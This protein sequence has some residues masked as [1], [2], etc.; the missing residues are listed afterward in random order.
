MIV[1]QKVERTITTQP[2]SGDN[3]GSS[4]F[5]RSMSGVS[6]F[7]RDKTWRRVEYGG[8]SLCP[9]API[10]LEAKAFLVIFLRKLKRGTRSYTF[11]IIPLSDLILKSIR[12]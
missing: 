11:P 1:V 10:S 7:F 9:N 8:V 6:V 3:D 5:G 4:G 2:Q 12:A